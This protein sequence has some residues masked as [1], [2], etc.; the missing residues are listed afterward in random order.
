MRPLLSSLSSIASKWL[1]S[2]LSILLSLA[3]ASLPQMPR[4]D[5]SSGSVLPGQ[6]RQPPPSQGSRPRCP[7]PGEAPW[8]Q[9][10]EDNSGL[11]V[12]CHNIN[13]VNYSAVVTTMTAASI[14]LMEFLN[15]TLNCIYQSFWESNGN[16]NI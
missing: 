3:P 12:S 9:C 10:R 8:C 1:L 14:L 13:Q 4:F 11:S 16:L 7:G 6:P 2:L 15:Q 5:L